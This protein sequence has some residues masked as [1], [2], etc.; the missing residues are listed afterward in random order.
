MNRIETKIIIMVTNRLADAKD[1][2]AKTDL[3][4]ELS[5]NL[6]QR[7][8]D[9]AADGMTEEEALK[10]AMD[11]LGD[12]TELLDYLKEEEASASQERFSQE[13][14]SEKSSERKENSF[15]F[16]MDN[17]E[18]S[19]EG[20]VNAAVST[21]KVAA[22][23]ARDVARDVSDQLREKYPDGVNMHFTSQRS[24]VVDCTSIPSDVI[25]AIEINLTN[26]DVELNC[27]SDPNAPVEVMGDTD[28]IETA[29]TEDG[30]LIIRQGNTASATFFFK[31]GMRYSDIEVTLPQ[32]LWDSISVKTTNGDIHADDPIASREFHATAT[33]GDLYVSN[34]NSERMNLRSI[35]GD[36]RADRLN[37]NLHA[38]TKSGD[39]DVEGTFG[40]CELISISGDVSFLGES[41]ELSGSSTSGDVNLEP[42]V[43]PVKLR[44]S[45]VS[46]DC[47]V[48][49]PA[50]TGFKLSYRTSCGEFETNIAFTGILREKRGDVVYQDG[51][52]SEIEL[53][54]GSGDLSLLAN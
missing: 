11:S 24:R 1:S 49:I 10:Q 50:N 43:L 46:G 42:A 33:S 18:E 51:G 3:I 4:E 27:S 23:Y 32:R 54:S 52:S 17:F 40:I 31:R 2:D 41:Q 6:Y 28:E 44:A 37:G 34:V 30:T 5:E 21:A 8:L 7:Y 45:S 29:I 19:L 13:K 26:G 35:S 53:S 16:R 47:R 14:Q 48:R 25:H 38:E 39:V 9:L 22:D 20:I 12:V 36:I 15:N